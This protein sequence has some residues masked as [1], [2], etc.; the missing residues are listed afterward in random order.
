MDT[1]ISYSA[2]VFILRY[3]LKLKIILGCVMFAMMFT[4]IYVRPD[5]QVY[6]VSLFNQQSSNAS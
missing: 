6:F 2:S 1:S 4:H 3:M 5:V